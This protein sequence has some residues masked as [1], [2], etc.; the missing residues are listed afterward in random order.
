M[1]KK[2]RLIP[3]TNPKARLLSASTQIDQSKENSSSLNL[4]SYRFIVRTGTQT[5]SGTQAQVTKNISNKNTCLFNDLLKVYLYLY[6]TETNWTSI[7]LQKQSDQNSLTS[8]DGYPSG[9]VRT[10]CFKGPDIGQLHH[11]N[12]NVC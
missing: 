2:R 7:H 4:I 9:S 12:V 3:Y 5:N 6:G 8:H 1:F 11:L 10:F